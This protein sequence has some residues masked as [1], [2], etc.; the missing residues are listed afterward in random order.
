MTTATHETAAKADRAPRSRDDTGRALKRLGLVGVTCALLAVVPYLA[1]GLARFRPWV[2]G[3]RPPLARLF[4]HWDNV[5]LPGFAGA[6]SGY[7]APARPTKRLEKELGSAVARNLG[8]PP[9]H[10]VGQADR[11]GQGAPPTPTG[12]TPGV[13]GGPAAVHIDPHEYDGID[14]EIEDPGHR[15]LAPFYEALLRTARKRKHAVTRIAHYGDSSIATDLITYTVRRR[16]QKRFG[17]AGHGFLLIAR[18]T[19]PWGHR[20]VVHHSSDGW[21]L[22]Q[23]VRTSLRSGLYGYGGVQYRGAPGAW[24][25]FG[26]DSDAPVGRRVS[27]F[28]LY[29]QQGRRGGRVEIDVDGE[30]TRVVDTR[31]DR[32]GPGYAVVKVPD[33]PHE[34]KLRVLAGMPVLYGVVMER[35]GPGVVYDSLGLVGA[36]ARRLLNFDATHIAEQIRHRGVNLLILGFGGNEADDP[37]T[38]VDSYED[39]FV[40][41]IERMRAGRKDM[42]CLVFAP[43]DQARRNERGNVTT[44]ETIPMIVAAQKRAA[45]REGCAFYDTF[46]AMGGKGAM[47]RWYHSRP[48]LA[49]SDF[50]H[51]TPEGYEVIGNMFYKALLEDFADWLQSQQQ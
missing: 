7:H 9:E 35:D 10:A 41:V 17:D 40:Q 48:R 31:A 37:D 27:R 32:T 51:A 8:E 42:G 19:M 15:G 29:Y 12:R 50:R 49:L 20:D 26:T 39:E 47:R 36:R 4:A 16:L 28:E 43:L 1:P 23:I 18:G 2:P 30:R 25:V 21:E 22:R 14:V 38:H 44:I 11:G 34:L 33:G 3:E 6:G 5:Q 46:E 13:S 24:S 45:E